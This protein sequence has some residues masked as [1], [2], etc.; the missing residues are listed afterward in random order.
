M[1][2]NYVNLV[3]FWVCII[4]RYKNKEKPEKAM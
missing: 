4:I 3:G 1:I 2:I